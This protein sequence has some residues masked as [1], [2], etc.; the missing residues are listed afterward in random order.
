[1]T[2]LIGQLLPHAVAVALSPMPIAAL[3][4][5]LLSYKARLNSILYMLGWV[6]GVAVNVAVFAYIFNA[7]QSVTHQSKSSVGA[8]IDLILGL[9][10]LWLAFKQWR[11]RPK[12]GETPT[13]PKWMQAV[14]SISPFKSF[15]I[16]F[17]LITVNAKNTVLDIA[18]G[19]LIAQKAVTVSE[20]II[21][22]TVYTVIASLTIIIPV[23][24][25]LLFG[26][27]LDNVLNNTKQWFIHNS[28][29]ILFV[30][31][32]IL[33]VDILGKAIAKM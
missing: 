31:F 25:F 7:Q 29:T 19:V 5:I 26:K 12:A 15:L 16:A 22:I 20:Q 14:E 24:A 27:K 6:I 8:I 1:M 13:I 2:D 3:I 30:L 17:A 21:A 23:L 4:L 33:G 10:L 11:S 32:L 9:F 18:A 28:A